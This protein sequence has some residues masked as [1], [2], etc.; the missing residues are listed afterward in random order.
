M[1]ELESGSGSG[2]GGRRGFVRDVMRR[3]STSG[4]RGDEG[5]AGRDALRSY[6]EEIDDLQDA[7]RFFGGD[8][9]ELRRRLERLMAEFDAVR[10]A[11]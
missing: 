5:D 6:Q 10:H 7:I 9:P 8:S 1:S 3:I 4:A 11:R 2:S